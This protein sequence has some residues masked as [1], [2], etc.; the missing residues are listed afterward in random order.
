[1]FVASLASSTDLKPEAY[2]RAG[3]WNIDYSQD[4]CALRGKFIRG[5]SEAL[6]ELRSF[7]PAEGFSATIASKGFVIAP[8]D[9][10]VRFDPD[11]KPHPAIGFNRLKSRGGL[12]GLTWNDSFIALPAPQPITNQHIAERTIREKSIL[13]VELSGS[14]RPSVFLTTGEMNGPMNAV[15]KCLDE[16]VTHWGIDAETQKTLSRTVKPIEQMA[17]ARILQNNY[18]PE[19]IAKDQSGIVRVRLMVGTD[20]RPTSCHIQFP[21]PD[22]SFETVTCEKLMKVARFEPA[23]DAGGRPVASYFVTKVAFA[24]N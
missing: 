15:R 3:P 11:L 21:S 2:T 9:A 17:W 13:G 1:M 18:P 24:V 16:L 10:L 20:G 12:V 23:L 8:G 5:K 6:L 19:M 4:S 7:S 14:V 22:I